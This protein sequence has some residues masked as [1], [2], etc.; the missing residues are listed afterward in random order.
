MNNTLKKLIEKNDTLKQVVKDKKKV[1]SAFSTLLVKATFLN[2]Q[3]LLENNNQEGQ[4][5]LDIAISEYRQ[6]KCDGC[7]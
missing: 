7:L 3:N 1:D 2:E 6:I 4:Y 5:W